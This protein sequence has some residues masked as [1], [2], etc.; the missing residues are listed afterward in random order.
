MK[1]YE[2]KYTVEMM[3]LCLGVSNSGYYKWR[4]SH[5]TIRS[6]HNEID[7]QIKTSFRRS[8]KT[9]GRPRI[10]HDLNKKGVICSK[11][12]VAR[13]MRVLHLIARRKRKFVNTTD[14]EHDFKIAENLLDRQFEVEKVNTVWVSDIT[15]VRV[16]SRWM[17]LTTFI[18]L[19]D[20]MVFK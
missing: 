11:T 14:S 1:N 12:T 4:K 17:Y 18:D 3:S 13:R 20:R 6:S 8:F 7:H 5:S 19:A 9:Y 16:A 10:A 15:Y 2:K